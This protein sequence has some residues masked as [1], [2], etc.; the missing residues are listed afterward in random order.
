LLAVGSND[1]TY[2]AS[3]IFPY[4]LARRPLL[5]IVHEESIMLGLARSQGFACCYGFDHREAL[6]PDDPL[7][8]QICSEWFEGP[9]LKHLPPGDTSALLPHTAAGMS[10]RLATIF[11][12]AVSPRV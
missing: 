4:L 10:K 11:D 2:S 5:T 6:Q 1:P 7:V 12:Q 3:K 9:G 8:A